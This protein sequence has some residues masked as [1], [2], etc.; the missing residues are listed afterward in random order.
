[1]GLPLPSWQFHFPLAPRGWPTLLLLAVG[2]E[3]RSFRRR[4][5]LLFVPR[6][7]HR[8]ELEA[9]PE[10]LGL[11]LYNIISMKASNRFLWDLEELPKCITGFDDNGHIRPW[12]R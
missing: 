8:D 10:E 11:H 1:M 12:D 2:L 6:T 3:E 5:L 4:L 9:A 7:R